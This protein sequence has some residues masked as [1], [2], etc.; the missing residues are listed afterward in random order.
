MKTEEMIKA[1]EKEGYKIEAPI[2][3][4]QEIKHNN[5]IFRIYKWENKQI[6]D[7]VY[8]KRFRMSEF[9]EFVDLIDSKK[10]EL[11]VWKYYYVKHF[12]K[13]QWNKKWRFSRLCLDGDS[14]LSSSYV[15]GLSYSSGN[16]RVV[17]V[18]EVEK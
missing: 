6:R 12:S 1:L 9:Q 16:G 17:C 8:P 3:D 15:V 2:K 10:I 4:Y 11:E 7:F 5:K 14:D 18:K 13:L